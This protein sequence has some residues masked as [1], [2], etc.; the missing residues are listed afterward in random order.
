MTVG[1]GHD[2]GY[3]SA[4]APRAPEE[5]SALVRSCRAIDLDRFRLWWRRDG[6]EKDPPRVPPLEPP[7]QVCS[8]IA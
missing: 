3:D 4:S 8:R 5:L 1:G 7:H 2:N 6:R